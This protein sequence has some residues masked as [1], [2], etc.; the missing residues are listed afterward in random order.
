MLQLD[1]NEPTKIAA[2]L[3]SGAVLAVPTETVWGFTAGLN[4]EKAIKKLIK[5]KDRDVYSGKIFTLVPD[6]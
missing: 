3:A 6:S 4:S 5:I 1:S 2:A